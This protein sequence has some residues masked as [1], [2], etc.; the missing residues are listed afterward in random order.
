[1]Y[2]CLIYLD[3]LQLKILIKDFQTFRLTMILS[4][5]RILIQGL[6]ILILLL[7]CLIYLVSQQQK[8]SIK[9]LVT[10]RLLLL[11]C[12]DLLQLKISTKDLQ[13]CLLTRLLIFL[14]LQQQKILIRGSLTYQRMMTV[15]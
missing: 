2:L 12:Q 8:I 10:L 9:D 5:E 13:I 4:Y 1:M 3:L 6:V 7:I 11:T 14:V 15:S